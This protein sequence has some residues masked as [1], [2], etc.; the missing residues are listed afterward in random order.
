MSLSEQLQGM[1]QGI[2]WHYETIEA[3][4]LKDKEI[5]VVIGPTRVGKG[6]ML[7]AISGKKM[8]F[9]KTVTKEDDYDEEG[10]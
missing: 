1:Y 3:M 6:T 2:I 4:D 7:E 5:F 8:K 10:D 9:W